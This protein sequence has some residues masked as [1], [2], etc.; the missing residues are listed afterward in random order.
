[1]HSPVLLP[2]IAYH[3]RTQIES[4]RLILREYR[5]MAFLLGIRVKHGPVIAAVILDLQGIGAD[6]DFSRTSEGTQGALV[7]LQYS[8]QSEDCS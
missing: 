1:V 2:R 3:L 6:Q 8:K 4:F 7:A 5:L